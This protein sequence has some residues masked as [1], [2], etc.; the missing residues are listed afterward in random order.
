MPKIGKQIQS[1]RKQLGW[2][3]EELAH[4]MGYKSKS[5]INK[6]EMG[7]NDIPQSKIVKFAKELNTTP[8]DLMGWENSAEKVQMY[9]GKTLSQAQKFKMINTR[10]N[11][12]AVLNQC[13]NKAQKL[14]SKISKLDDSDL[15][16]TVGFVEGL[17]AA[18]K[19]QKSDENKK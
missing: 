16:K 10:K 7:I 11:T 1:R 9:A 14:C 5:S 17:L 8:A 3:Q 19:Y 18:D 13:S 2:T 6:I 4:K 15:D 12:L